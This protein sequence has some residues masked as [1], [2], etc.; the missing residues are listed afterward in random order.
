MAVQCSAA[1]A[2]AARA[3]LLRALV[4]TNAQSG[5]EELSRLYSLAGAAIEATAAEG[6]VPAARQLVARMES[7][8]DVTTNRNSFN[9]SRRSDKFPRLPV[10]LSVYSALARGLASQGRGADCARLWDHVTKWR[11][12]KPDSDLFEASLHCGATAK[13]PDLATRLLSEAEAHGVHL[14]HLARSHALGAVAHSRKH[15]RTAWELYASGDYLEGTCAVDSYSSMVASREP[16]ACITF[17]RALTACSTNRW[18]NA[19]LSIVRSAEQSACQ[20]SETAIA[21]AIRAFRGARPASEEVAVS[22][23]AAELRLRNAWGVIREDHRMT[24]RQMNA[25]VEVYCSLGYWQEAVS[26]VLSARERWP[27]MGDG[28]KTEESGCDGGGFANVHTF[29]PILAAVQGESFEEYFAVW[30][31]MV[32]DCSVTPTPELIKEALQHALVGLKSAKRVVQLL[33]LAYSR[34]IA[35]SQDQLD[36]LRREASHVPAVQQLVRICTHLKG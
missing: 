32:L 10:P 15:S 7:E 31:A 2:A 24:L 6:D 25:F 3:G 18:H 29:K 4:T 11:L 26:L 22:A 14:S 33:E 35:I 21:Q 28:A 9:D 13:D 20:L 8:G 1:S 5:A 17:D 30:D 16:I 19:V 12:L 36:Q 23:A 34:G 27:W